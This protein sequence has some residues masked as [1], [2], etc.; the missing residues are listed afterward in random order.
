MRPETQAVLKEV[1]ALLPVPLAELTPS[2]AR[3][4]VYDAFARFM[5]PPPAGVL[6][7]RGI[8][9]GPHGEI[10]VITVD[11]PVRWGG[12]AVW[13]HGGGWIVGSADLV[14]P[15]A[16]VLANEIGIR[17]VVVDYRRAPEHGWP[18][19]IDEAEA[20][21]SSLD[22]EPLALVGESSGGLLAACAAARLA[23]RLTAHVLLNPALDPAM[24]TP[25]HAAFSD[26]SDL[27]HAD[28]EYF[29]RSWLGDEPPDDPLVRIVPDLSPAIVVTCEVDP[30]RDEGER[31]VTALRDAG[32]PVS[33]R[34]I[35]G[36]PHSL[37]WL[38]GR[39]PEGHQALRWA[40][41][42]LRRRLGEAGLDPFT[43]RRDTR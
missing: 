35:M 40:A 12:T 38:A 37:F 33:H 43:G 34:R 23:N 13:L 25:S 42:A 17:V 26:A 6:F 32:V 8:V 41:H 20:V 36:Q 9:D 14:A 21:A 30:L 29:W 3:R 7:A 4:A 39:L 24:D 15:L 11:P 19:A 5:P 27:P 28:M 22:T 2:E 10:P 31:H 1:A 18:V 16:A